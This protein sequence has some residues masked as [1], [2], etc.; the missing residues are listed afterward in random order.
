MA[1]VK[2]GPGDRKTLRNHHC[3]HHGHHAK[4]GKLDALTHEHDARS[5]LRPADAPASSS[6]MCARM[7][8]SKLFSAVKPRIW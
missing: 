2:S 4:P 8:S 7:I 3:E 1:K 6:S 5:R